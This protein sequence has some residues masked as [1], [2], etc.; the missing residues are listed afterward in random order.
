[1]LRRCRAL[2]VVG[3]CGAALATGAGCATTTAATT[4]PP[5]APAPRASD[6]A[7]SAD[8]EIS[9]EAYRSVLEAEIKLQA[10]DV[11]A[12][13]QLLREAVLHDPSSPYLH[14]RLAEA[15]LESG[16]AEQA[17]SSAQA[18][19]ALDKKNVPALRIVG[20][21]WAAAGDTA[22]ARKAYGDALKVAP[23]DRETS[24]LL[25]ELLVE[26][27][28]LD[29]AE[30]TIDALMTHEPGAVDGYISLARVFAERG[31]V[32]RAFKH[33]ER[34]LERESDDPDALELKLT[35]LWALGRFTDALRV[36]TAWAA[37]V[38]DEPA[39][40]R[41]LLSA[42]ALAG[43]RDD[44]IALAQAWLDDDDSEGMRLLVADGWERAGEFGA[45]LDAVSPQKS[46]PL[47]SRSAAEAARLHLA[48][49]E[50]E[51]AVDVVC[52]LAAVKGAVGPVAEIAAA[53]C[54]RALVRAKKAQQAGA[55]VDERLK[56]LGRAA[57][58]LDVLG[59]IAAAGGLD[60]QRAL[61]EA[62]AAVAEKPAD[63]DVIDA[64]SRVHEDLGDVD[65]ARR[66][67]D[68][69]L[70]ARPSDADLL[71]S[72]AR[73]LDRQKQPL[74]AV[75]IVERLMDRGR[76]TVSE[77]NFAAFSLAEAGARPED[78]R[79]YAWRAL[80]QDPLNG[81]V[82]DTLGWCELAAGDVDRA[83]E[84]L[85]RADRLSPREGEI[86]FHLATAEERHGDSRAALADA[87]KA[88]ALLDDDDP[89]RA[90]LE[91]LL[92]KL[93]AKLGVVQAGPAPKAGP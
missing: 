12:A 67:L 57:R 11:P 27:G 53:S 21:S 39:V 82:V 22:S 5:A 84:T 31:E 8:P 18:A 35:L 14:V 62:D 38:G 16:D 23:G 3:V 61:D 76:R 68:D 92:D 88:R 10:G 41:D 54:A 55:L 34:A 32:E 89:I 45:A 66:I 81:Y 42:T 44:A 49:G 29:G 60:K 52:P 4:L 1:V 47:S 43:K 69:A 65:G 56:V 24:L 59:D 90:R 48:R 51:A 75:E 93:N 9:A 15:W 63:A 73:H 70:R 71:F 78:A 58:L 77:L 91:A 2:V 28:D 86:L 46:A 85:R 72:L 20:A 30:R 40:R 19:L 36:A 79:R 25:A 37:A 26:E 87:T 83:L 64:A 7:A 80:V 17:R 74:P 33:V 13:I 6:D 50:V